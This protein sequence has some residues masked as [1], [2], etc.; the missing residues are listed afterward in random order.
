[1]RL[2]EEKLKIEE[3]TDGITAHIPEG[4][5]V[6]KTTLRFCEH[7][8]WEIIKRY[9]ENLTVEDIPELKNNLY[10]IVNEASSRGGTDNNEILRLF[11]DDPEALEKMQYI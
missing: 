2:E 11:S 7:L 6:L 1:M 10:R 4:F 8:Q 9:S 3:V 5:L